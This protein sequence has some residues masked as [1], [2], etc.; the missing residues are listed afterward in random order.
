MIIY[1]EWLC[2]Y[3]GMGSYNVVTFA[4]LSSVQLVVHV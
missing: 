2:H 4:K 3:I 1:T